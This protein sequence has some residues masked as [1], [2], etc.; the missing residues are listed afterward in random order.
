MSQS[1]QQRDL[2]NDAPPLGRWYE[3]GGGRRLML[4][5]AGAGTPAVVLEAGAGAFG[6]DYYNLFELSAQ[7]TSTVLYDRAGSGWSDP[8]DGPRTAAEIVADLYRALEL[9]GVNGPYLMVGHSLGA[10]LVL[11]FAQRFRDDVVGLVL[12][13]PLTE[14][15][16]LPTVAD[17][18]VVEQMLAKLRAN[19][20]L[21][22]EWYPELFAD[23]EKLPASVRGPLIA[24]HLDQAEVG[25]RDMMSAGPILNE[26]A[27]G[28]ALPDVPVTVLTGMKIDP[29]P[30]RSNAEMEAF[31]TI[32]LDAHRALVNSLPQGEHRVYE[33]VGHRL[34]SER[35]DL[36]VV[37]IFDI[38]DRVA[39][40]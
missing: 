4:H 12:I 14:G 5:H 17:E 34:N 28:P 39:N 16:P 18:A 33:D 38:L 10:L 35:P 26:V 2:L 13:E 7:R 40:H 27:N 11:A 24:R 23:F 9:A 20:E 37:A 29:T 15:I 19:P 36:V 25:L 22:R 8:A 30:G 3:L 6:L 21:W 32:K 31:N 1:K